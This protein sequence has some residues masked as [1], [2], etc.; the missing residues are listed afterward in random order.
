MKIMIVTE[1]KSI[2]ASIEAIL[3]K[4]YQENEYFFDF[5]KPVLPMSSEALH[6]SEKNGVILENGKQ[7]D[8]QQLQVEGIRL[9]E[10]QYVEAVSCPN[11]Y[12]NSTYLK[13]VDKVIG[14]FTPNDCSI[15]AFAKYLQVNCLHMEEAGWY[16]IH[17]F[18]AKELCKTFAEDPD[19]FLN[20]FSRE[21]RVIEKY[22]EEQ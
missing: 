21:K 4:V 10:K 3:K 16:S 19:E 18:D 14:I 11:G 15:L 17:S 8:L 12:K 9:P 5:V 6:L 20:V 2:A 13:D 1:K 7:T 22:A